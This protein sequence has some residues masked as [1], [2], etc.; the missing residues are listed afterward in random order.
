M[1]RLL[2]LAR[3]LVDRRLDEELVDELRR[4]RLSSVAE[5]SSFWPPSRGVAEDSLHRLEEPELAHVV[6]LVE[7]RDDDLREVELALLDEVLDAAGRADHDV[8]A[9]S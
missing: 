1:R 2:V 5:K 6:G 9:A 3:D 4:P 7:H 8:D